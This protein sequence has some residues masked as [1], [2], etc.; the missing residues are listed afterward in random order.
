MIHRMIVRQWE[1]FPVGSDR[2]R[3]GPM[4]HVTLNRKGEIMIGAKAFEWLGEPEAVVLLFDRRNHTIGVVPSEPNAT[5][6]FI[7]VRKKD[8]RHRLVRANLFC[9][10]H[11]IY[12]PRTAAF[13]NPQ[14]DE[15]GILLLDLRTLVGIGRP[16]DPFGDS[17]DGE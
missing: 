14:I 6:A 2:R 1:E 7:P 15:E 3:G 13:G 9:R 5:N 17:K 16:R 4:L 8:C 11:N 10:H 12:I